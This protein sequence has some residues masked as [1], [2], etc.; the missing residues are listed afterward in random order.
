MLIV[1]TVYTV[2]CRCY[3]S[4]CPLVEFGLDP[5]SRILALARVTEW[6]GLSQLM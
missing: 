6:D 2:Q 3:S 1:G 4:I 5:L